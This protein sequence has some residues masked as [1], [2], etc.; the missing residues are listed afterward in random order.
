MGHRVVRI[1]SLS[2]GPLWLPRAL[3]HVSLHPGKIR[4]SGTNGPIWYNLNHAEPRRWFAQVTVT[5]VLTAR[6]GVG[7]HSAGVMSG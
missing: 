4:V 5:L 3:C 7:T 6:G 1:A 2:P